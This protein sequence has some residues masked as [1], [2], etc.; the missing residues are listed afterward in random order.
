MREILLLYTKN[1]HFTFTDVVCLQTDG[2]A[3][4]STLRQYWLVY[5]WL[6]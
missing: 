2:V 3:M 5:L 6:I 1:E 4:G